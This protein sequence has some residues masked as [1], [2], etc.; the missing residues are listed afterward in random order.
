MA[1]NLRVDSIVPAT[2]SSVSIGTATGGVNIPGV[3]TY[4]DVTNVDSIGIVTARGGIRIGTGGTVGPVGSGI[5]TYYGD[6]SQLTGAG[7]T[8]TNGADNRVIT[9]TSASAITGESNLIFT[10]T[11]LGL[12]KTSPAPLNGDGTGMIHVAGGNPELVLERTTSGTESK[13][14]I[15]V[16]DGEDFKI[17]VKDGSGSTIDALAIDTGTGAVTKPANPSFRATASGSLDS[18]SDNTLQFQNEK[19]DVGGYYNNSNSYYTIPTTGYYKFEVMHF[20]QPGQIAR[21][22]LERSTDGGSSWGT[23]QFG[24]RIESSGGGRYIA[25]WMHVF[26][27][28]TATNLV[29]VRWSQGNVHINNGYGWFQGW[30]V[31]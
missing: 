9:A 13:A 7:P 18:N 3:L 30:L 28:F 27:E 17:A 20:A 2:G 29:R 6:G 8:F 14:S 1:S 22:K 4:E 15:R 11:R 12:N 19:H 24:P 5:V 31:Q 26:H 16:T 10:G 21:V 25:G 23:I